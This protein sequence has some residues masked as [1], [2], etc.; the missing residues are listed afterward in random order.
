MPIVLNWLDDKKT[1]VLY[2]FEGSWTW[3][4]FHELDDPI[5]ELIATVDYRIDLIIDW[6]RSSG[7]PLGIMSSMHRAGEN[8]V[9]QTEGLT[10]SIAG[11]YLIKIMLGIFRRTYPKAA[12]AYRLV[13][14]LDEAI[15]LLEHERGETITPSI[16]TFKQSD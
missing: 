1:I 8:V 2:T 3:E 15:T 10:I 11:P 14:S 6:T 5:W 16:S 7:F 9:P 4:E 12:A 13:T